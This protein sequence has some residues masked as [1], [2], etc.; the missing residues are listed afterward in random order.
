MT[1]FR[2]LC[3]QF[4]N[5]FPN[6][7]IADH[8]IEMSDPVLWK[9]KLQQVAVMGLAARDCP[10]KQASNQLRLSRSRQPL[11]TWSTAVVSVISTLV[12]CFHLHHR[13]AA[14]AGSV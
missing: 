5:A 1:L 4:G 3:P 6:M 8:V 14:I 7:C 9:P 2:C 10:V 12:R 13:A 11:R